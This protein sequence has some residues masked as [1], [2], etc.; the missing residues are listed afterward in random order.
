MDQER[1]IPGDKV[2]HPGTGRTE[3]Y[4]D[5]NGAV[6]RQIRH[7][8]HGNNFTANYALDPAKRYGYSGPEAVPRTSYGTD[9]DAQYGYTVLGGHHQ[10]RPRR[11]APNWGQ[12]QLP[13]TSAPTSARGSV[14]PPAR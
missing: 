6:F 9:P 2:L 3:Y 11:S 14:R 10:P 13:R 4:Q 5:A 8:A 7:D 1:Y 12:G